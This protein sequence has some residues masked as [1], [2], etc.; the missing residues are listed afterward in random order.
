MRRGDV[1]R[2]ILFCSGRSV[3]LG[4]FRRFLGEAGPPSSTPRAS[5]PRHVRRQIAHLFHGTRDHQ[6]VTTPFLAV[7]LLVCGQA[8]A[9]LAFSQDCLFVV[10]LVCCCA[11]IVGMQQQQ[12]HARLK[13]F[14]ITAVVCAQT[15]SWLFSDGPAHSVIPFILSSAKSDPYEICPDQLVDSRHRNDLNML[16]LNTMCTSCQN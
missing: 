6:S 4:G 7:C 15:S 16:Q 3:G 2:S 8:Q 10:V 13:S 9:R 5:H 14:L 11:L 12:P 1:P